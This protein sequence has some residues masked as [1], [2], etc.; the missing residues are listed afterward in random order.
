[1]TRKRKSLFAIG[2]V[3]MAAVISAVVFAATRFPFAKVSFDGIRFQTV[4]NTLQG[5]I[6]IT[7]K[8]ID[9]TGISF[10]LAYDQK[11]LML[12]DASTNVPIEN[13]S[14]AAGAS[15]VNVFN[16][17]HKYFVQNTDVFP[18]G[19]FRD[20]PLPPGQAIIT[21]LPIIGIADQDKSKTTGYGHVIMNFLPELDSDEICPDYIEETEADNVPYFTILA[22]QKGDLKFGRITFLIKDPAEFS[23]L[24]QEDLN[25]LIKIDAFSE[26]IK[27]SF[28]G[29]AVGAEEGIQMSYIN[30]DNDIDWYSDA[31]QHID[32]EINLKPDLEDVQPQLEEITV[33]S[34]DVYKDGTEDDLFALLNERMSMI[35]LKYSNT[36][37]IPATFE[38]KKELSSVNVAWNPLEGEYTI[39]QPYNDD[40]TVS[41]TVHVT[42][43][44][45]IG[46]STDKENET[47]LLSE[48]QAMTDLTQL[49][50]PAKTRPVLD[51]YIPNGGVPE[52]NIGWYSFETGN[53]EISNI[54]S[55]LQTN[56]GSY[57]FVGH[58]ATGENSQPKP[59]P[60]GYPW[61]TVD[62]PLPE[63]KVYRNV[64][65]TESELP[66]QL[67]VE[68]S[69]VN[70]DGVLT[71]VV[72][73]D[74]GAL[75]D[76]DTTF[77]IKMPGGELIDIPSL[78]SAGRYTEVID[79]SGEKA[80]ITFSADII[81][82]S[83]RKLAQLIN[84]G[85]RG[86]SFAVAPVDTA[87][88]IG[89]YTDFAPNPR[90]NIYLPPETEPGETPQ[91]NYIFDYSGMN[92][93]VFPVKEGTSLPTTLILPLETDF[94]NTTY[95]GYDGSEK[96]Y[97]RTIT[98]DQWVKSAST[99]DDTAGN[100]VEVTGTLAIT[101]Y[102]NYGAVSNPDNITV[103]IRYYVTQNDGADSIAPIPNASY[104]KRQ[105][106]YDYD[107]L[108]TKSFEIRNNGTTDI[109][110]LTAV[111]SLSM[112]SDREA[113]VMTKELP[114][115]LRAGESAEMDITTKIGLPLINDADTTYQCTVFILSE[116][117]EFPLQ[118]FN[119]SFT[120]TKA[121]T[122]DIT[123]EVNDTDWGSAK[124]SDN[125]YTAHESEGPITI[126][127]EPVQDCV[128]IG[129]TVESGDVTLADSSSA[130]TTFFMPGSDVKI[131][132]NFRETTRAKLRLED[133]MV[134]D[135]D[136][137]SQTLHDS[138][139]QTVTFDPTKDTYYVAVPNDVD[140]VKL[141]FK[142]RSEGEGADL[143]VIHEY[144]TP[145]AV[146]SVTTSPAPIKDSADDYYKSAEVEL[147][148]SPTENII[149]LTI[150]KEDDAEPDAE[151]TDAPASTSAP[152]S[153]SDPAPTASPA[154]NIVT[155][156]YTVHIYQKKKASD[157]IS[158]NYGNS[159][160]GL[161]MRD[162]SLTP[163]QQTDY[164][165]DFV[166]NGYMF[167]NGSTP[168]DGTE[169]LYYNPQAWISSGTSGGDGES[170]TATPAPTSSSGG[171][172]TPTPAPGGETATTGNNNY[173]LSDTAL[174]VVGNQ[175][176]TDPGYSSFTNSIGEAIQ[177]SDV[178]KK[179][180][181]NL[182][183]RATHDGSSDDFVYISPTTIPL[184]SSATITELANQ[185][186]RPGRYELV[187]E[188]TDFDG[189]TMAVNR[190]LI[191]LP[192]LGDINI[193]GTT[194]AN[195]EIRIRERFSHDI[196][197]YDNV[198]DYTDASSK[199]ISFKADGR[200]FRYRVCDVNKDG[201]VNAIDAN[202]I[203]ASDL[204]PYYKNVS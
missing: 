139:W 38:W 115:I 121:P 69:R 27:S 135:P 94:V 96:G 92:S 192:A 156:T 138:A 106:G 8:N 189:K 75:I 46:F 191:I 21:N 76:P 114:R 147:Q 42:P 88:I 61:L 108:Q 157:L 199:V 43:I 70:D 124:T 73:Y 144:G 32:T 89:P 95:S 152:V 37:V 3:V 64:V 35:L 180:E 159:P 30:E 50:L 131:K 86:G 188:F 104:D 29:T 28:G 146:T 58:L 90:R 197:D 110:G 52:L 201:H 171:S 55:E 140:K 4:N 101:S 116:N 129:W 72:K 16:T 84:L 100:I 82:D 175:P 19:T 79:P 25:K 196:A 173:D 40:F 186:I 169:N 31:E 183:T 125:A 162:T 176:F 123:L 204:N 158:F 112:G 22:N 99:P 163:S 87:G 133:F 193:S 142:L 117:K 60:S 178:T 200:L 136:D 20:N 154:P 39:S 2:T 177:A 109:S 187:Y 71:L 179:I 5:S 111:I 203:R 65:S 53:S 182:L 66:K 67:I 127:A 56:P 80:T 195:D 172:A 113:F 14:V 151:A 184:S 141:W 47:Y 128:F 74:G 36:T 170:A 202:S 143:E 98:V 145:P 12:S 181:V 120:V 185:K 148:A 62:N 81:A 168:A 91:Q 167:V 153:T 6:D 57:T 103:T 78:K 68:S 1:M 149:K 85:N 150:S 198:P 26:M 24:S 134:K 33:S 174:F 63:I 18:Q 126:I 107:D 13:P 105:V 54:P 83:E 102:T 48:T 41:V 59:F 7:L 49:N 9:A 119:I 11:Y 130:T 93:A 51:T 10:C 118:Q 160:Y 15:T 164:K 97:L 190:P 155:R 77:S 161:I 17:E 132:A 122:Y 34:Y 44:K 166:T 165:D 194:D 23:R 137:I 45:L